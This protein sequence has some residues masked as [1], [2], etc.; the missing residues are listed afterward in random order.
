MSFTRQPEY[1]YRR[2]TPSKVRFQAFER[3]GH[4]VAYIVRTNIML[5]VGTKGRIAY[6]PK[7]TCGWTDPEERYVSRRVMYLRFD[8]HVRELDKQGTLWPNY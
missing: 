4:Q 7:C 6:L 3:V 8:G 1:K 2:Y 5:P